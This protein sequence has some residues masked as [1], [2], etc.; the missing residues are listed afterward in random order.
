MPVAPQ[1]VIVPELL[2]DAGPDE[3]RANL[4]DLVRINRYFGGYRIL[5][6][7]MSEFVR[8][9]D[10]FSFLDVGAA[11]GDMGA[12]LRSIYPHATILSLDRRAQHLE[13]AAHPK[14]VADAFRFPF[15]DASVDFVFCSLFLHHFPN[16]EVV[17]LLE[18]FHRIARRAVIA[19]DLDRGPLAH[20][21][22]P[23][24]QWLFRWTAITVH[25]GPVSV[26]AAFKEAEL[27][28]L[29]ARAGLANA[30]VRTHRPWSR[31]S[32]VARSL[33]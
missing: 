2:D 13:H 19:I 25:D 20:R 27:R 24:T 12:H 9:A 30:T 22:L 5:R 17:Q 28:S 31:V 11:S 7:I 23:A 14:L 1:R 26:Q 4:R 3:A 8:P 6:G 33:T 29:A 32:L 16:D 10:S 15:A 18:N 21:F